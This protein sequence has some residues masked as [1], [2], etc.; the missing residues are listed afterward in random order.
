LT[1]DQ[2]K[3]LLG[4]KYN[5]LVLQKKEM[6]D[7]KKKW[8]ATSRLSF[9]PGARQ[10]CYVCKKY[11]SVAHAHHTTPLCIQFDMGL[12]EPD[13]NHV[14][15]CPTHH[16]IVHIIINDNGDSA[17]IDM[18]RDEMVLVFDVVYMCQGGA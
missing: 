15:L 1:P 13:H 18:D 12:Q 11:K 7:K 14:W 17:Y 4:R 9:S 16:S 2:F 3:L 5:R 6:I 8:I 10:Y